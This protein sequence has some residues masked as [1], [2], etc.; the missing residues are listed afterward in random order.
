MPLCSA[1]PIL[2]L[3]LTHLLS[4]LFTPT[5]M[6]AYA[7]PNFSIL[8]SWVLA[9]TPEFSF[10]PW[11][12]AHS[13]GSQREA[14]CILR[15]MQVPRLLTQRFHSVGAR[16]SRNLLFLTNQVILNWWWAVCTLR[17]SDL[18]THMALGSYP[19]YCLLG[20]SSLSLVPA[21]NSLHGSPF[22]CSPQG[23]AHR[24]LL[25]SRW[26]KREGIAKSINGDTRF[27]L[28][29]D[30]GFYPLLLHSSGKAAT[31]TRVLVNILLIILFFF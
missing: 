3:Y 25:W 31:Y 21:L 9:Q 7:V 19:V 1:H 26:E 30:W 16:W 27:A 15:K 29:C 17:N 10:F 11:H 13:S 18:D 23:Q 5:A 24:L 6:Y 28:R 4:F 20:F 12:R 22:L 8:Q 14:P 2:Q